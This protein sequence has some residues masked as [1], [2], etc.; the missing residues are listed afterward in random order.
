MEDWKMESFELW[1]VNVIT[2]IQE[3]STLGCIGFRH[4]QSSNQNKLLIKGTNCGVGL[5]DKE[6][7]PSHIPILTGRSVSGIPR[8]IHK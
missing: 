2:S 4:T 1:K 8:V 3:G 5:G 7:S 6:R